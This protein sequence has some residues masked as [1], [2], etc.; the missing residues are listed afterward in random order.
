MVGGPGSAAGPVVT[1][2]PD[3]GVVVGAAIWDVLGSRAA[4][5]WWT[6]SACLGLFT[7]RW[8]P[9]PDA[10]HGWLTLAYVVACAALL[11]TPFG[12]GRFQRPFRSQL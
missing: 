9:M 12:C 4:W 11:P 1:G 10:A 3:P 7:A 2:V 6:A 5:P 8:V